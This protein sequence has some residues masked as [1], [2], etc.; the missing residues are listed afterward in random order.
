MGIP[1]FASLSYFVYLCQNV[2]KLWFVLVQHISI[3]Y[4]YLY[5]LLYLYLWLNVIE[6]WFVLLRYICICICICICIRICICGKCNLTLVYIYIYL[7]LYT[8]VYL[9]LWQNVFQLWFVRVRHIWPAAGADENKNYLKLIF[10]PPQYLSYIS[11]RG[12][13]S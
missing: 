1:K 2:I 12:R 6:L 10:R 4:L 5:M 7:Y 11:Q 8:L 9:Y 13:K 3:Y